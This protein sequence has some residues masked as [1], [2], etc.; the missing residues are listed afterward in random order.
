[1]ALYEKRDK[2]PPHLAEIPYGFK[3]LWR[4]SVNTYNLQAQSFTASNI[5]SVILN[6]SAVDAG[7]LKQLYD[8]NRDG[9]SL[10]QT[11][12]NS[13]LYVTLTGH[14]AETDTY[15]FQTLIEQ[16]LEIS[17][18]LGV[19]GDMVDNTNPQQ[20]VIDH[21]DQK[22]DV[23]QYADDQ[24]A[25]DARLSADE[26]AIQGS[27][28]DIDAL[29]ESAITGVTVNGN[30]VPVSSGTAQISIAAL[31]PEELEA[32]LARKVDKTVAGPGNKIVRESADAFDASTR[33][34]SFEKTLLSLEDGS[35]HNTSSSYALADLLGITD[36]EAIDK[37]LFYFCSDSAISTFAESTTVALSSLY[38]HNAD[39]TI[40]SP[41]ATDNI[42]LVFGVSAEYS[43][44]GQISRTHI[45][46]IGKVLSATASALTCAFTNLCQYSVY[47]RY[48]GY[49]AGIVLYDPGYQSMFSTLQAVPVP[50]AESDTIALTNTL[51]YAP[52]KDD[53]FMAAG[54]V[55]ANFEA[56]DGPGTYYKT[57]QARLKLLELGAG[58]D[59][60]V[61]F[62]PAA[63]PTQILTDDDWNANI[64][65]WITDGLQFTSRSALLD[66]LNNFGL[67]DR[68]KLSNR[69]IVVTHYES[70]G[71]TI[72]PVFTVDTLEAPLAG[73]YQPIPPA[74]TAGHLPVF[75]S[76]NI[77]VDSGKAPSDFAT[78]AQGAKADSAIQ[79]VSLLGGTADGTVQLTVDGNAQSAAVTGLGSAAYTDSTEYAT[80]A[81]GGKADSALQSVS[82]AAGSANGTLQLTANGIKQSAV[83][84]PGLNSAAYANTTD[85]ATAA[86]GAKAD[87][88]VQ[89]VTISA[90]AAPGTIQYSVNGGSASSAS[91]A[92]LG[93]AAYTNSAAYATAAQGTRADSAL[94]ASDVVD[95]LSSVDRSAPLSANQGRVLEQLIQSMSPDGKPI[96][97]FA[98]YADA[99]TNTSQYAPD[100]QPINV[101][102]TIY[103]AA[104][105]NHTDQPA[106]YRVAAVDPDGSITYSFVRILPDSARDFLLNPINTDEIAPGAITGEHIQNDS[107]SEEDIADGAVTARKL[108]ASVQATLGKADNALQS[109]ITTSGAGP[110]V[111]SVT[112][113]TDNTLSVA[114][115]D[116]ILNVETSGTG[117]FVT[118]A[119]LSGFN[120]TLNKDG[121]ALKTVSVMGEGNVIVGASAT[122]TEITLTK[123]SAL[124]SLSTTGT[125]NVITDISADGNATK[126]T[127]LVSITKTGTGNV[128]TN[129][130][131]AGGNV[132]L[133]SGNAL[134]DVTTTGTGN[135]VSDVSASGGTLYVTKS[136][137]VTSLPDASTSQKGIVQLNNSLDSAS[138]S[139]A[140]TAA[141][142][143]ALAEQI[144]ANDALYVKLSGNQTI[145]GTKTLS[146]D[147]VVPPKSALSTTPSATAYATE[148]QVATRIAVP[149]A[150][151]LNN[152]AVFDA[153]RNVIDSGVAYTSVE[154]TPITNNEI[155]VAIGAVFG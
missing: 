125:G 38:R 44:Y 59:N 130:S 19:T 28:E 5:Q 97:G 105:E 79:S 150:A 54:T 119:N 2:M 16:N 139:Q 47:N 18:V 64:N 15:S 124:E 135:M 52:I 149:S 78:A 117:D 67:V 146:S 12:A 40:Y 102:D 144:S 82:L 154:T 122:G 121:S 95:N 10:S 17:G 50:T 134:M 70:G 132:S 147:L 118:G 138:T 152:I 23:V 143:K 120:L 148:A 116:H 20:P 91:V 37:E 75:S 100:L 106:Q 69:G 137:A 71:I 113:N 55:W 98:T 48:N 151:T 25:L 76:S 94:Q 128:L 142:G 63:V 66:Y 93:S 133:S 29:K 51:Y 33:T 46:A 123:G 39:G 68:Y 7:Q 107:I 110:V 6:G 131:T 101:N 53:S 26:A 14:D 145:T 43:G 89:T 4:I 85:F 114:Y 36:L 84:V 62:I 153:N 21:D 81:Q 87:S 83:T 115:T 88:A 3:N 31:T 41:A 72:T 32:A 35:T 126:G 127:A 34:L 9:C 99:Y 96:G 24:A 27:A 11:G 49:R 111:T 141:Q 103:I 73:K 56:T 155:D 22:L 104:D 90:G 77:L 80:A 1:M 65:L 92:G 45:G 60:Y 58:Y 61:D 112:Q 140:L 42:R 74:S 86:Q 13:G 8:Y 57:E 136:S 109:G 108:S 30:A 129:V